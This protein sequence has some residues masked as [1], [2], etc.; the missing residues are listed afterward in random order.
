ML[1]GMFRMVRDI[2]E[3]TFG[4]FVMHNVGCVLRLEEVY[5]TALQFMDDVVKVDAMG[6]ST[7]SFADFGQYYLRRMSRLA[8]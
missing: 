7:E 1:F 8:F 4:N 3:N 6:I 2:E 5:K